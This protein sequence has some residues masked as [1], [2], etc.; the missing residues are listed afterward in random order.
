MR[1]VFHGDTIS[2]D[3]DITDQYL[4]SPCINSER[5]LVIEI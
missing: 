3:S 1:Q 4:N 2:F 5:Y